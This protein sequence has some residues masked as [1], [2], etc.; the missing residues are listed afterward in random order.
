MLPLYGVSVHACLYRCS[1]FVA[2]PNLCIVNEEMRLLLFACL[3]T[4]SI[5]TRFPP[6]LFLSLPLHLSPHQVRSCTLAL[7]LVLASSPTPYPLASPHHWRSEFKVQTCLPLA[8]PEPALQLHHI[9][10]L[11]TTSEGG[12]GGREEEHVHV[13]LTSEG[14]EHVHVVLT[15]EGE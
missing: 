8:P 13:V 4:H 9:P 2:H 10:Q 5:H 14:E 6:C 7:P 1:V 3:L 15:S 12:V 11:P